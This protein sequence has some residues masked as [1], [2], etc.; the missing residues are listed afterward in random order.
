M[1]ISQLGDGVAKFSINVS[2]PEISGS[3]VK[4]SEG[5]RDRDTAAPMSRPFWDYK[6]R[7]ATRAP[8]I[9]FGDNTFRSA[10]TRSPDDP[11]VLER[12]GKLDRVST[13]VSAHPPP[14]HTIILQ[15]AFRIFIK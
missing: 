14:L 1:L 11:D 2:E 13:F 7:E 8:G 9:L 4:S 6:P 5:K 10:R 3:D 12:D 15:I